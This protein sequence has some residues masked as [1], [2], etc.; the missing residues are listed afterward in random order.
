MKSIRQ[1]ILEEA[2]R[3]TST[4]RNKDYGEP[5][6]NFSIIAELW[7]AYLRSIDIDFKTEDL[8]SVAV[9]AMMILMKVSRVATSPEKRDHWVDIA[10]YAACGA[11]CVGED[12]HD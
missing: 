12:L 11:Q 1:G 2:I 8:T 7:S 4:D 6:D 3:I 10:G 9:A 5:E